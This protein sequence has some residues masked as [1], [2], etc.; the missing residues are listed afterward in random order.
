ML[1]QLKVQCPVRNWIAIT[2]QTLLR[3]AQEVVVLRT[4]VMDN[5]YLQY[6]SGF[7]FLVCF[8]KKIIIME[9]TEVKFYVNP[10]P[11]VS[12]RWA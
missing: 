8:R 1:T 11:A 12:R 4:A 3:E 2:F 6:S 10:Q 5:F 9:M 7:S